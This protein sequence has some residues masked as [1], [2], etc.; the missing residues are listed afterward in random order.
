[1]CQ[2]R[3]LPFPYLALMRCETCPHQLPLLSMPTGSYI[4]RAYCIIYCIALCLFAFWHAPKT[5]I[6]YDIASDVILL[7]GAHNDLVCSVPAR[8]TRVARTFHTCAIVSKSVEATRLR[9]PESFICHVT[10]VMGCLLA[11]E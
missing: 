6:Q 2:W 10:S 8:A 3:V 4:A 1:M 11:T 5:G 9:N 7:L